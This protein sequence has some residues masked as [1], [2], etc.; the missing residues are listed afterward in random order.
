MLSGDD[1][2][3]HYILT[4]D[5]EDPTDWSYTK[6]VLIDTAGTTSGKFAVLD[7]D[8]DGFTEVKKY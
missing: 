8:G 4:P 7:Y 2:G 3:K 6:H 1:D 5:S